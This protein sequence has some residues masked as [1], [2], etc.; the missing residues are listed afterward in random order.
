MGRLLRFSAQLRML[1]FMI[2][3]SFGQLAWVMCVLM[4]ILYVFGLCFTMAAT[5]YLGV[6]GNPTGN[7]EFRLEIETYYG[8][9][10][11]S[12]YSCF[13]GM[14]GGQS[15]GELLDPLVH[16]SVFYA[17]IFLFYISF[18]VLALLN[19][20][21]GVFVDGAL[22]KSSIDR[23]SVIEKE[24][25]RKKAYVDNLRQLFR[26]VDTDHSGKITFVEFQRIMELTHVDAYLQHLSIDT[27][28]I[29]EL[30]QL[31]DLNEDGEIEATEFVDNLLHLMGA[32]NIE[33]KVQKLM[34]ENKRIADTLQNFTAFAEGQ[35]AE[36]KALVNAPWQSSGA[37]A[38]R[39][40]GQ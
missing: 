20:V 21:T 17:A 3:E 38:F 1:L 7:N 24:L 6:P 10:A 26:E 25:T 15:W 11:R 32:H 19:M 13:R 9:L 27:S 18:S 23:D 2:C 28:D 40:D 29:E 5:E 12:I 22:A 30:Y 14:T 31:L 35:F 37:C 33:Q 8:S 39:S 16:A 36:V 34:R 4:S